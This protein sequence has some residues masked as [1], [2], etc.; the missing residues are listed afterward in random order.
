MS[1]ASFVGVGKSYGGRS[2]LEGVSF[3]LEEGSTT[4]LA[5]LSGAGK[6]TTLRLLAGL[7]RPDHGRVAVSGS[8]DLPPDKRGIGM[9]FQD[10][11][12][13][14]HMSVLENVRFSAGSAESARE[15]LA[16][17]GFSGREQDRPGQLSGGE[18]QRLALA[19][20]LGGKPTLLLL[21]EPFM[22]L[23]PPS[24]R[25]LL[26]ELARLKL[27]LGLTVLYVTHYL[28]DALLIADQLLFLHAGRL[29]LAGSMPDV[30]LRSASPAFASFAGFECGCLAA[31]PVAG[32]PEPAA[33]QAVVERVLFQSEHALVLARRDDTLYRMLVPGRPTPGDRLEAGP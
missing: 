23:D 4:V 17:V 8:E 29:E 1:R 9:V 27:R 6:T 10:L 25:G 5:G 14:G 16:M 11:G 28:E 31:A 32:P 13:F 20:A 26:A 30:L 33:G 2:V 3:S 19:R 7:D 21:D 18:R 15:L 22:N 12:L 24:R